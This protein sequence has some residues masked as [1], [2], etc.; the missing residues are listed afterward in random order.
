MD[1]YKTQ[2]NRVIFDFYVVRLYLHNELIVLLFTLTQ[3]FQ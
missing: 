3:Y 1:H 2:D